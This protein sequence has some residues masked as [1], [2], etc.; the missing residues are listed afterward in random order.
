MQVYIFNRL[1]LAKRRS[2]ASPA[3]PLGY[4]LH[5][6]SIFSASIF[7]GTCISFSKS[8]HNQ[9]SSPSNL[10]VF[11]GFPAGEVMSA[12][13]SVDEPQ[14]NTNLLTTTRSRATSN[15]LSTP[16][17]PR[18]QRSATQISQVSPVHIP[19]TVEGV[20]F[21]ESVRSKQ[22]YVFKTILIV[23]APSG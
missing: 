20:H 18:R 8:I 9:D 5:G 23:T 17:P 15:L 13:R 7:R 19:M 16:T 11:Q 21:E 6:C 4:V 1:N 12:L 22:L 2:N 14:T 10:S 3:C